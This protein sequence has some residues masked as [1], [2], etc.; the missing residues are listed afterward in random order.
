MNSVHKAAF[1]TAALALALAGCAAS[2]APGPSA[3]G[4]ERGPAGYDVYVTNETSGSLS[5]ID[6]DTGRV[7]ATV[8][9]GQRPRG[10]RVGLD[11]RTLLISLT[12]AG[13]SLP[14]LPAPPRTEASRAEDG[15][16]LFDIVERRVV[17]VLRG[18]PDPEQMA[19]G[20]DGKVFV[21][22]EEAAALFVLDGTDGR[23]LAQIP[24]GKRPE[25]VALSPDGRWVYVTSEDDNKVTVV[26]AVALKAVKDIP[27]GVRP[28]NVAFSPDGSRAY[29]PG[30][31]DH[32]LTVI[33][34]ATQAAVG[35][36]VLPDDDDLPMDVAVA[37][38]G[39]RLYLS[40]GRGGNIVTLGTE[41]LAGYNSV[42]TGG[43]PWGLALSPD[44]RR[45]YAANGPAGD[46]AVID[47]ATMQ[48]IRK[49]VAG[50]GPWGVVIAASVD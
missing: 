39:D 22:S 24:V 15:V 41:S 17:R 34:T 21:A 25:G 40:T 8:P 13:R 23:T 27:V 6:G 2:G 50:G 48:V 19:V 1:T 37:P 20:G 14:G 36:L 44:G 4:G 43:R 31:G 28:R 32:S 9:L 16:A 3:R 49:V 46:V 29:V 7:K 12:G 26:D 42:N 38:T 45:L 30:E 5:I 18:V 35:R 33:D 47:T 10:L 11:G